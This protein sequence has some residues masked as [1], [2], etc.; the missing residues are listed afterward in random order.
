MKK[1]G[2]IF[3]LV[4]ISNSAF[5]QITEPKALNTLKFSSYEEVKKSA[6]I[7]RDHRAD[8]REFFIEMAVRKIQ[9][10]VTST[11]KQKRF[12]DVDIEKVV[13][14]DAMTN[15]LQRIRKNP[16]I[17]AKVDKYVNKLLQPGVI[18]AYVM[19]QREQLEKQIEGDVVIARSELRKS[20]SFREREEVFIDQDQRSFAKK[21]WDHL[22]NDLYQD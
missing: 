6:N 17:Q 8:I 1:Y 10:D 20:G 22:V 16:T 7:L 3:L 21:L 12:A 11:L 4:F 13:N 2:M 5:G 15:L 14:S 9:M 19:K 18:E